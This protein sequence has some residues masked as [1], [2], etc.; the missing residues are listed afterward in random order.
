MVKTKQT[1]QER[2]EEAEKNDC[3]RL[4]PVY[5]DSDI[6]EFVDTRNKFALIYKKVTGK[7]M[8]LLF[9]IGDKK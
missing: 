7:T 5:Y 1:K 4:I 6:V 8:R 9:G 2:K 3:V